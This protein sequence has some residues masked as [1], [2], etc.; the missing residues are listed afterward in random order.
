MDLTNSPEDTSNE[1]QL[2]MPPGRGLE[3]CSDEERSA[4]YDHGTAD[5]PNLDL[6]LVRTDSAM[7]WFSE[8]VIHTL[9]APNV[10]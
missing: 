4:G 8:M 1:E 10:G 2:N 3:D 6:Q 7:E 9:F 5:R